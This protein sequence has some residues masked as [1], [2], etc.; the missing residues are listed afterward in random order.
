MKNRRIH[1]K[2]V[3]HNIQRI[4]TSHIIL[5]GIFFILYV[6]F[7][8]PKGADKTIIS[9]YI[10]DPK[11]AIPLMVVVCVFFPIVVLINRIVNKKSRLD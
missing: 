5:G 2:K 6:L 8:P 7:I 11:Q 4:K 1:K 3:K 10:S 9:L